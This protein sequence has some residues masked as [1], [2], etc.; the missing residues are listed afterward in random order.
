MLTVLL[1]SVFIVLIAFALFSL[2]IIFVKN[3]KFHGTCASNNPH[4][5]NEGAVCGVCGRKP[6]EACGD[7]TQKA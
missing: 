1:L 2:R 7:E 3:G 6:G 5:Q 4:L